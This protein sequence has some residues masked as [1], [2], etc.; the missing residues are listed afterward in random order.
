MNFINVGFV[1]QPLAPQGWPQVLLLPFYVA[2]GLSVPM[3]KDPRALVFH[4]LCPLHVR[5]IPLAWPSSTSRW[6]AFFLNA[7]TKYNQHATL[8]KGTMHLLDV[9]VKQHTRL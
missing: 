1:V 4:L 6:A 3:A 2:F 8:V 9:P 7:A 5:A